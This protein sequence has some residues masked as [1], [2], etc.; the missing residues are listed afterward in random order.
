MNSKHTNIRIGISMGDPNGIGM[1]VI[2]K[3]F[4]DSRILDFYTPIIY[5]SSKIT[6]FY[7]KSLQLYDISFHQIKKEDDA[8]SKRL[9]LIN[10]GDENMQIEPGNATEISGEYAYNCLK[11]AC[12]GL[13][14]RKIDVL[15]TAPINKLTIKKNIDDF[16]GH[17][18]YLGKNFKGNPLML[19]V[20]DY[21]KIALVTTH[22]P[23]TEIKKNLCENDVYH[24]I[25][26]LNKTL[27]QDFGIN[28]PKIAVLGLNPHAGEGGM[29]G[30]EE[31]KI[32]I[33]AIEK[34]KE[35]K[36]LAFGPY[37]ADSFFTDR[38]LKAF[39][40]ILAM[41]HDQGL[42]PFKTLSFN[43]GV[44]YTAGL[45]II[46]TSPI[47]GTAYEIAG[48]NKANEQSFREAIYLACDIFKQRKHSSQ[49]ANT[50]NN[51]KSEKI[52]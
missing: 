38:N 10:C 5:G 36:V 34:S 22:I 19:M 4:N 32:I 21:M 15:I 12:N 7:R 51:L 28:K 43:N 23:V 16:I 31:E 52:K 50:K 46:R 42:T 9:N 30:N 20:S 11:M 48:K 6:N 37:P 45:N 17:T 35:N 29:L 41:Y 14:N 24:K 13:K 2:I 39:D 1:E 8:Q 40:A 33:P 27:V 18:E 3:T 26:L 49:I 25:Q 44:N 47:H